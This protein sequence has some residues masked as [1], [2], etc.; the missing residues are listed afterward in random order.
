MISRPTLP[1][2]GAGR[3]TKPVNVKPI[4]YTELCCPLFSPNPST[5]LSFCQQ[6]ASGMK[7]LSDRKFVHRYLM[8]Q[9]IYLTENGVC[10]VRMHMHVFM[11]NMYFKQ[12]KE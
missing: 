11:Y 6:I 4:S 2:S 7:F 5:L 12:E 10:K 3:E 8:A 1:C 9:C